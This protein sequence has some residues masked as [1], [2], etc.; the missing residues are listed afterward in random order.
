[1]CQLLTQTV[2]AA[3][4]PYSS[5]QGCLAVQKDPFCDVIHKCMLVVLCMETSNFILANLH[6]PTTAD[7]VV[8]L[9]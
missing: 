1:M 8:C 6:A 9:A 4:G 7:E 5:V 2:D 3:D